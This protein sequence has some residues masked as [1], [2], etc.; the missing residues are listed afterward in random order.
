MKIRHE[1]WRLKIVSILYL[2][3]NHSNLYGIELKIWE[4]VKWW[5]RIWVIIR[6]IFLI[7]FDV[8]NWGITKGAQIISFFQFFWRN[9]SIKLSFLQNNTFLW[10]MNPKTLIIVTKRVKTTLNRELTQ[11]KSWNTEPLSCLTSTSGYSRIWKLSP[12]VS[13]INFK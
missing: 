5:L 12:K 7:G 3:Q 9:Y 6:L 10:L 4:H 2:P 1:L 13:T 11:N 8:I